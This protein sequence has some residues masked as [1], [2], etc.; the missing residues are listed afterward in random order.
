MCFFYLRLSK[1][2]WGWWFETPSRSLWRHCNGMPENIL[3]DKSAF[4]V[5][6]AWCLSQCWS[7]SVS[8]Y[9]VTGLKWVDISY[10][11]WINGHK[12]ILLD[13]QIIGTVNNP[14]SISLFR[15]PYNSENSQTNAF[16]IHF[17]ER[18]LNTKG[19]EMMC[20][21]RQ[22]KAFNCFTV[23]QNIVKKCYKVLSAFIDLVYRV[24]GWNQLYFP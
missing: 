14:K 23:L 10:M 6:M 5:I 11:N 9:G 12:E 19:V 15:R 3:D 8:P 16:L 20:S 18:F 22:K 21:K 17:N 2:S 13:V 7:K 1:Q 4:V 24:R